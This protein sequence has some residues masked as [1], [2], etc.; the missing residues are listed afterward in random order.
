MGNEGNGISPPVLQACTHLLRIDMASGVDSLSVPI[1][2]G[3]LLHG[4]KE[5]EAC[6]AALTDKTC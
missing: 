2:A 6:N 1:A 5:R 3:I 4:L